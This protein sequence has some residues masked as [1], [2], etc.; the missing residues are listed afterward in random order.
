M[1]DMPI[2]FAGVEE[3]TAV[4]RRAAEAMAEDPGYGDDLIEPP[5]V[6]GVEQVT[7][8]GA[9]IRTIV[10]TSAEAQFRIGRELRR[11]L[12]EA[13]EAA[14]IAAHIAATRPYVRPAGPEGNQ[15]PPG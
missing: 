11:R 15:E 7:V 3:A 4:L 13:L 8:D 6:L 9:S 2:G 12:T 5:N 14:G 1:V 10:K